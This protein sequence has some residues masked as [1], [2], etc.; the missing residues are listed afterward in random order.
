MIIHT[1]K[2][3]L[4]SFTNSD[5]KEFFEMINGDETIEDYVPYAYVHNMQEATENVEDYVMG[6]C[7]NDFY[8]VIERNK[9]MVGTI[10]AV[11]TIGMTLDVSIIISKKYRGKGIMKEALEAFVQWLRTNTKYEAIMLVISDDNESSIRLA[12]KCGAIMEKEIEE[13]KVYKIIL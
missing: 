8:L 11:R 5:V 9:K 12:Q 6:D 13:N 7:I 10:I 1:N 2:Y 4:R 3:T